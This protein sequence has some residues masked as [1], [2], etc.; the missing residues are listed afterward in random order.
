MRSVSQRRRQLA[1]IALGLVLIC[2]LVLFERR[3]RFPSVDI[4]LF[5]K[6]RF[7]VGAATTSVAF[8]V[9]TGGTFVLSLYLQQ[10]RGHTA[11]EAGLLMLPLAIGS[12]Y[13]GTRSGHLVQRLGG[14]RALC[15]CG[16]GTAL[17]AASF[18]L[19]DGDTSLVVIEIT[20]AV[21]GLGFGGAFALG[22]AL[23]MSV[24]PPERVGAGSAVANTVRHMGTA[25]GIAV[26]GSVLASSYQSAMS[27]SGLP[28]EA[29]ASLGSTVQASSALPAGSRAQVLD[30][31]QAAFID[32][33]H[34]AMW[35]GAA[36]SLA[37]GLIA[38]VVL[39]TRPVPAPAAAVS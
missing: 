12:M 25:L 9:G 5:K 27:D 35:V 16:M 13:A 30:T 17:G 2:A 6:P 1:P 19:V 32:G 7:A 20:L 29:I 23:A 26:L 34:A 36:L 21:L 39:R 33:F 18:A 10:L 14:A 28:Q 37:A 24:V 38:L 4:E 31:A 22:M 15:L 3:T 8:F 11:I